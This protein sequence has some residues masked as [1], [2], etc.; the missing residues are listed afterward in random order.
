MTSINTSNISEFGNAALAL[1]Q[2]FSEFERLANKIASLSVDSDSGFEQ[3]QKMLV[4]IDEVGKRIGS[5]MQHLSEKLEE[6]RKN[7]EAAAQAVSTRAMA[8]QQRQKET[9]LMLE[10]LR[11]LSDTVRE[12]TAKLT[13]VRED[14]EPASLS[15]RKAQLANRLPE[16]DSELAVIVEDINKLML[17]A[18]TLRMKT[19][20]RNADSLRQSLQAAR[21]RFT[22]FVERLH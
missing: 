11:N 19:L 12:V 5:N 8:V 21:H 16:F 2:D 7:T 10:R 1:D 14:A 9:E 13:Q 15:D 18:R 6:A 17:D 3:A 22:Q 4:K 20:E